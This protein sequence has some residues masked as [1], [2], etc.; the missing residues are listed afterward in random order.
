MEYTVSMF[1]NATPDGVADE[2]IETRVDLTCTFLAGRPAVMYMRNGDPGYPAEPDEIE[3]CHVSVAG[4]L[5][6]DKHPLVIL[7]NRWMDEDETFYLAV[8]DRVSAL[9]GDEVAEAYDSD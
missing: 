8:G 9:I 4:V 5:L 6:A 2:E 3:L 7:L 1:I